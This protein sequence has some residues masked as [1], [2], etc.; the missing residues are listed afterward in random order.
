M[1]RANEPTFWLLHGRNRCVGER[2]GIRLAAAPAGPLSLMSGD[3]SLGGLVLPRGMAL[4]E[5]G[6]LYMLVREEPGVAGEPRR[7]FQIKRFDPA[8]RRFSPLPFV[9]GKGSAPRQFREAES[10]AVAGRNLYVAD[11][12]NVRVQVFD[13]GTLALRHLWK[14]SWVPV[15][16]AAHNGAAYILDRRNG[17]VYRHRP[18]AD[19]LTCVVDAPEAAGRWRRMIV[20]REGRLYL[21]DGAGGALEVFTATGRRERIVHDAGDVRD[22]FDAPPVRMDHCG[23]FCMPENL[24]RPCNRCAAP[25]PALEAPTPTVGVAP[26]T[27][28]WPRRCGPT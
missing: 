6:T 22:N 21:A 1:I 12:G 23:R 4:S 13:C 28:S 15:D 11:A 16:V 7:L 17:R 20:D 2:S 9:G 8:T 24:V 10:I 18:G 3:G 14:R 5:E 25:A 26:R 19:T 27:T